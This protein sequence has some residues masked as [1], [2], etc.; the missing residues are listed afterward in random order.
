M[1][2]NQMMVRLRRY[3]HSPR[4]EMMP[5]IDVIF[6]LMTFFIYSLV[7]MVQARLLPVELTQLESGGRASPTESAAVTIDR[8]GLLYLDREPISP[9]KL[10]EQFQ[11]WGQLEDQP[12]VFIALE[13]VAR[14]GGG[15]TNASDAG[16]ERTTA[17]ALNLPNVDRGPLVVGLIQQMKQAGLSNFVI[18]GQAPGGGPSP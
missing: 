16:S 13:D 14:A 3:K 11:Q 2:Y 8:A 12:R 18:V 5:M 15:S 10:A 6:V 4:I 9:L 1:T 17:D 7:T